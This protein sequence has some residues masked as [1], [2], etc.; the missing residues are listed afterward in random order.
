MGDYYAGARGDP[1]FFGSLLGKVTSLATSFIPG[2]AIVKTGVAAATAGLMK[3]GAGKVMGGIAKHPVLTAAGAAGAIG[4]G[5]GV[6]ASH[7]LGG[8]GARPKGHHISR[9]KNKKPFGKCGRN[10]R[11]HPCNHH[12]LRRGPR[13]GPPFPGGPHKN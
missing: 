6:A 4:V 2:G 8:G 9:S 12:A 10:R 13:A 5:G 3:R 7:L 1:G 11:M